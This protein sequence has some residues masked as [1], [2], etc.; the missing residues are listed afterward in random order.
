MERGPVWWELARVTVKAEPVEPGTVDAAQ[1]LDWQ[2][3]SYY[4]LKV[5]LGYRRTLGLGVCSHDSA[6]GVDIAR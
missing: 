4:V 3:I 6:A 5:E 2:D 1:E